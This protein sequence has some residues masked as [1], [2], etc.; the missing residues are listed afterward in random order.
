MACEWVPMEGGGYA[1]VNYGRG[2]GAPRRCQ[3][4]FQRPGTRLCDYP[5]GPGKKTC[6]KS[7]CAGCGM[8]IDKETDYCPEHRAYAPQGSLFETEPTR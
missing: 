8:S 2:R 7:M 5:T 1:H 4:C 3:F 6:S